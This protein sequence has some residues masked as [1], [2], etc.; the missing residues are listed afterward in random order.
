MNRSLRNST[1]N[2]ADIDQRQYENVVLPKIPAAIH[3]ED[4][5]GLVPISAL[6][7]PI[8]V[9]FSVWNYA[10]PGD[11]C[12]LLCDNIPIGSVRTIGT[13]Q[14]GDPL[15]LEYYGKYDLE[16]NK[17]YY[18]E[19]IYSL[20]YRT[21]NVRNGTHEDSAPVRIEIDLTPPGLPQ[22]E[23]L[24]F[25]IQI[26]DG[27][28]SAE[29]TAMGN[30]L[31]VEVERYTD[32]YQHDVIRTFWD[33]IEGPSVV[34]SR[35]DVESGR[36]QIICSREFLERLGHFNG[37]VTYTAMDRAGNV[38]QPSLGA[39]FQSSVM[40]PDD[41][42]AP[43]IDPAL[44]TLI[45]YAEACQGVLVVIPQYPGAVAGDQVTL[46]WEGIASAAQ[47]VAAGHENDAAVLTITVPYTTTAAMP[48]GLA[49]VRYEVT[50]DG[51]L[52]G[53]SLQSSIE[54]FV[55][56]PGPSDLVAPVI[57]GTSANPDA[58]DN[59]IDEDDY[60]LNSR[61]VIRWNS[62]FAIN[63]ELNLHWGHENIAQWYQVTAGDISAQQDL[64]IPI[65]Q[66][67]MKIGGS[68]SQIPV[69]YT[70]TRL[71]N[72]NPSKSPEQRVIVRRKRQPSLCGCHC[73]VIYANSAVA[74]TA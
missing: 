26:E 30:Q 67:I 35:A 5:Q 3:D 27:L 41:F 2:R 45:D 21:V 49:R 47:L 1:S 62:G 60:E 37:I 61:A 46:Y 53:T 34:V 44:G 72:P 55:S 24:K 15:F 56:W 74:M 22:L 28:T 70:L 6:A 8:R 11:T 32:M 12:Q 9:E 43:I 39:P 16:T 65:P 71:G 59:F 23:P 52:F 19:G 51:Q 17:H 57:Q 68:G 18:E 25:P 13:E 54:V 29:L 63:D 40:I 10:K 33:D 73:P 64:L 69:F 14:P 38:S 20:A 4:H 66:T 31:V 7:T 42:P 50:R 58:L 36:V 48:Q